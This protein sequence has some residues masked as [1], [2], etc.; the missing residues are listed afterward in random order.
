MVSEAIS[1]YA[2]E[3]IK[4]APPHAPNEPDKQNYISVNGVFPS[5]LKGLG[6]HELLVYPC[7]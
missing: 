1:A 6:M 5:N 4:S 7:T 2:D 3:G